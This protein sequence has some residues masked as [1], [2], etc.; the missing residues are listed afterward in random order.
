MAR[1]P[2]SAKL[3]LVVL[4]CAAALVAW[5]AAPS[6]VPHVTGPLRQ[7]AYIWQRRWT[8]SHAKSIDRAGGK[9]HTIVALAAE[10]EWK[11][12]EPRAVRVNIPYDTLK[13]GDT[14]VGLALRIG[15]YSGPFD[16][17]G[18]IISA[19]CDLA[20]QLVTKARAAGVLVA[21]LQIDFDCAE[22]KL[23]GYR[24]WIQ[25][26]HA[27]L[28]PLPILITSL[29]SWLDNDAMARL[30]EAADGFILQVHSL[31][32]PK[33][34][35]ADFTLCD[36]T[37]ARRAVEC[38]GRLAVPFRVALPTYGYL[39]AFDTKGKYLGLSAEGPS[40]NW[41]AN[42]KV[43]T[44][45]ADADEMAELIRTW[46][47]SRPGNMAG[48]I[49]YRL[50]ID[51][52]RLN[53]R[54]PTLAAVMAGRS[55]QAHLHAE[56]RKSDR[57]LV[58][59]DLVNAG[60]ADAPLES[61]RVQVEWNNAQLVGSDTSDG[62]HAVPDPSGNTLILEGEAPAEPL[63]SSSQDSA[64]QEPRPAGARQSLL[65]AAEAVRAQPAPRIGAGDRKTIGWL[66]L[67]RDQEVRAHVQTSSS[68]K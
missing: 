25:A 5:F 37:A 39:V 1:M 55:P 58:E 42:A 8:D 53:W 30:V 44:I 15:A 7:D 54:W 10:I 59:V 29:P 57:G 64:R 14:Q 63:A 16:S 49:W 24:T 68:S 3:A 23:D 22:S 21:E 33:S 27:R 17:S 66:R 51:E 34:V 48:V 11:N 61:A 13:S 67:D 47:T 60:D 41:P 32:R 45:S 28:A 46:S 6:R 43:K 36:P 65:M 4:V 18:P 26:L 50:P 12:G 2:R 40:R 56:L 52:D 31:D 38:A 9:L 35:T 19:I 62:F 20:E